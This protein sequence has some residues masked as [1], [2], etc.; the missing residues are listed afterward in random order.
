MMNSHDEK[1]PRSQGYAP[2]T[3]LK[4][5]YEIRFGMHWREIVPHTAGKL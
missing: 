2:V 3:G 1:S 5:Y 4:M